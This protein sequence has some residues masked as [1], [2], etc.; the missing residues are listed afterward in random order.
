MPSIDD[1]D[2]HRLIGQIYA[3]A[4]EPEV[5]PDVIAGISEIFGGSP[6]IGELFLPHRFGDPL[7][8]VGVEEAYLAHYHEDYLKYIPWSQEMESRYAEGLRPISEPFP[9]VD[10]RTN[11]FY[12]RWMEPQDLAP[13]WP[14]AVTLSAEHRHYVGGF[15]VFRRRGEGPFSDEEI[16]SAERLIPHLKRSFQMRLALESASRARA[17]LAEALDRLPLGM[18]VLDEDRQVLIENA[19]ATQI[20]AM[21][22]GIRIQPAGPMA[23]D[24]QESAE[25]RKLIDRAM[26]PTRKN[27][28]DATGFMQISRPS[29]KQPL[30][31]MVSPLLAATEGSI[32]ARAAMAFF[33]SDPEE[34]H[35]PASEALGEIY[36]L[37]PAES[38]IVQL[39]AKGLSLEEIAEGRGISVNTARSHLKHV[40]SKTGTSRQSELLALVMSG[41]GSLRAARDSAEERK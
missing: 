33:V 19:K 17:P 21:D 30:E 24:P 37:T 27:S 15:V 32:A 23:S 8:G 14:I 9:D 26:D 22:D 13:I 31:V 12:L 7:V 10:I 39:L 28:F 3:S 41:V 6:V 38:E 40:F 1:A 35:I 11:D 16:A 29:E 34:G 4:V 25:L 2:T 18:L 20:L 36:S 5:W